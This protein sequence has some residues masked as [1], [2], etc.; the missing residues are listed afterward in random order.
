M[1]FEELSKFKFI[2]RGYHGR[3]DCCGQCGEKWLTVF[4]F[5]R[6]AH[7]SFNT[8]NRLVKKEL[9]FLE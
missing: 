6:V 4:T 7:Q 1:D 5:S 2:Q 3:G 8:G 9:K